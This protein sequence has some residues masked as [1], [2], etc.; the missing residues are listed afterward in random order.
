MSETLDTP[1]P[2][3]PADP[4]AVLALVGVEVALCRQRGETPDV[5]AYCRRFPDL[6]PAIRQYLAEENARPSVQS[7]STLV[8]ERPGG[9]AILAAVARLG[10][11]EPERLRQLSLELAGRSLDGQQLGREL[12][13]CGLLTPFQINSLLQGQDERLLVGPY[14][15]LARLGEGGM[16]QVF[17]ARHSRLGRLV[18]LKL[19]HPQQDG[20]P[21]IARRFLREMRSL[22]RLD[23]PNIVHALDA[24]E[25]TG[26]LFLVM[27]LVE[28]TDLATLVKDKGALPL[29]LACD[30]ARQAA[31]ALQHAHEQG[32]VH[33]D[34][35]PSNL[36]LGTDGTVRLLDLGLARRNVTDE[37]NRSTSLTDT[38]MTMG[39]P[40]YVSPEQ[41]TDSKRVDIRA[42]LYSLGCTLYH[43]L[44][45]RPPF[46]GGT[47]GLKLVKHQTEQP[48]VIT[49][50]RADV[51]AGL[52]AVVQKLMAK[53]PEERYQSPAEVAAVLD[54]LLRTRRL[55]GGPFAG[56]AGWVATPGSWLRGARP[57][58]QGRRLLAAVAV[59]VLLLGSAGLALWLWPSL[60]TP[61]PSD[62]PPRPL[63]PLQ[64]LRFKKIRAEERQGTGLVPETVQVLG[65][66]RGQHGSFVRSV[67]FHPDGK[68]AF[69]AGDDGMV[70][71]W[72]TATMRQQ[73]ALRRANVVT[74]VA[75]V[76]EPGGKL[77]LCS[78]DVSG[79]LTRW[80]AQT[81]QLL[82]EFRHGRHF[83]CVSPDGRHA[84]RPLGVHYP[85][86]FDFRTGDVL[87]S[88][89]GPLS[90]IKS[91]GCA[92][93][94]DGRKALVTVKEGQFSLLE[95][96]TGK[97]LW[98]FHGLRGVM[99]RL[100]IT[101]DGKHVLSIDEKG[102]AWLWDAA[103]N[104]P[105][106]RFNP[107][108]GSSFLDLALS[109]TGQ[110]LLLLSSTGQMELWDLQDN[111][112][113][114]SLSAAD[115][116]TAL[117]MMADGSRALTGNNQ[118]RVRLWDL[119]RGVELC[120]CDASGA[121]RCVALSTDGRLALSGHYERV[122]LH[123]VVSGQVVHTF[124]EPR[125]WIQS[126][127]FSPD[128]S[129]F[130]YATSNGMLYLCR[131]DT[132]E[133][134][135]WKQAHSLS[136]CVLVFSRDGTHLYS[137]GGN[138]NARKDL[139]K[140]G[141]IREWDTT[142]GAAK[143][144]L[145]GHWPAVRALALS[146]DGTW[147]LS[148]GAGQHMNR[149][150]TVRLWDLKSCKQIACFEGHQGAVAGVAFAPDG[151]RAVS[152]SVYTAHL[153][154]LQAPPDKAGLVLGKRASQARQVTFVGERQVVTTW[155]DRQLTV[156]DL[157][158]KVL[159]EQS[160]PHRVN[161]LASGHDDK[162]LALANSNG[163]VSILRLPLRGR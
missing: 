82:G 94:A 102:I 116:P 28:G 127:A 63:S 59:A 136:P 126:V 139:E 159:G 6:A 41:I 52:A 98:R 128:D 154:N 86:L 24:G 54:H 13:Q 16:G 23:H 33:R 145:I 153:W 78:S 134:L 125:S 143:R 99:A 31:L 43:L 30:C 112:M 129:R 9:D 109:G 73:A 56:L 95:M 26:R 58:W 121:A 152:V 29:A 132:P 5:E 70:R 60:P 7:P 51:P 17:K 3:G 122:R 100:A 91:G 34:V 55:A 138:A 77:V 147:L 68:R 117:A 161:G 120:P 146:P 64:Q 105:V 21:D 149:D 8:P 74:A 101:P 85:L 158:G 150:W 92:F 27:E 14:Q 83:Q 157:E 71:V 123:N 90:P 75:V 61:R 42:D 163:T 104:R 79:A 2:P 88:F 38:G 107:K 148:G 32:L 65:T 69:S 36:L 76:R 72:D 137:A 35:K 4:A 44:T 87:K 48:E 1:P 114:H 81:L 115:S 25:D 39:T 97:E 49:A 106:R 119:E 141:T 12:L 40:D 108:K 160:L 155:D 93:S 80:D 37:D 113:I 124:R 10:L 66:H 162:H 15:L 67:A 57:S 53:N 19:I 103:A 96:A 156:W 84:L 140:E 131:T 111:R 22:A 144:S 11:V 50:L 110:R 142:T 46:P 130:A 62:G 118:G 47:L 20:E 89:P 135:W 133:R 18:A 151:R 45:G